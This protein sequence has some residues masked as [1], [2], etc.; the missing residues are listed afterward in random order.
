M[1]KIFTKQNFESGLHL[2]K[3][4][5]YMHGLERSIIFNVTVDLLTLKE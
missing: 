2:I 5:Q 4:M 3:I 1:V